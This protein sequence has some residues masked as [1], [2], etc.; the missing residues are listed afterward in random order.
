[1]VQPVFSGAGEA[2]RGPGQAGE[3][4]GEAEDEQ[5]GHGEGGGGASYPL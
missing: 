3:G 1:M 5:G 2:V 4:G